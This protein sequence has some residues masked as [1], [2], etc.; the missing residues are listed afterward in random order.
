MIPYAFS[1]LDQ[2]SVPKG[3]E[4]DCSIHV[5]KAYLST[6]Y[7][8]SPSIK[9]AVR[10]QQ[11]SSQY[12]SEGAEK[13]SSRLKWLIVRQQSGVILVS[14]IFARYL[15]NLRFGTIL[16]WARSSRVDGLAYRL[17]SVPGNQG[18]PRQMT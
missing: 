10:E 2:P 9:I 14:H 11:E 8:N 13:E 7:H 1:R 18:D 12:G 5:L 16:P 6:Q 15:P 17:Y 3:H 4:I